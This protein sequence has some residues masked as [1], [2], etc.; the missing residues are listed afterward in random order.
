MR[1][2]NSSEIEKIEYLTAH[3]VEVALFEPTNT[4][5]E[6][7]IMDATQNIRHFFKKNGIHDYEM[8]SQGPENKVSLEARILTANEIIMSVISLYRPKTKKGDPRLWVTNL[9]SIADAGD[10]IALI[11]KDEELYLLNI[12]KTGIQEMAKDHIHELIKVIEI[13]S[14]TIALELLQKIKLV[15]QKGYIESKFKGDTA[16]GRTLETELGIAI[17]SSKNPDYK[18]IELKSFRSQRA[19][20]MN[21]F[22]QVPDWSISKFKSSKE[23]LDNFG[24][25]RDDFFRLNCTVDTLR[26][27]S[28]GLRLRVSDTAEELVEYSSNVEIADFAAWKMEKLHQRLLEKHNETFWV[29]ADVKY[30]N[31][32]EYFKFTKVEHTRKPIEG[33]F[34]LLLEQGKVN[35]DHLIKLKGKSV[36]ERGPLFK[37]HHDSLKLL[38]PPSDI[39][40]LS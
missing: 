13:G 29:E 16:V 20:R 24:Y 9:R 23:I 11:A 22:A 40:L 25:F 19:N 3:N 38:F 28:Q 31:N 27:N 37:L 1:L 21:L 6:K 12:T 33:Q 36:S 14:K 32:K 26:F 10:I 18:G 15:S 7:S 5:L 17:N 35:V 34:D 30:E 8:Q 4:G 39:Y 2:L